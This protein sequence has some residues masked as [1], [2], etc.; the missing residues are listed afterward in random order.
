[1]AL[2]YMSKEYRLAGDFRLARYA[3]F[4][5]ENYF[6][7]HDELCYEEGRLMK[8]YC[9]LGSEESRAGLEAAHGRTYAMRKKYLA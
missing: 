2:D 1:M 5:L 6:E 3:S 7:L 9:T 4:L 8:E